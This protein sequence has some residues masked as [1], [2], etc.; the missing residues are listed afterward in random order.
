M[1]RNLAERIRHYGN[2]CNFVLHL[3]L[4]IMKKVFCVAILVLIVVSCGTRSQA[5]EE[6]TLPKDIA[7][8]PERTDDPE[9][10]R[11]AMAELM[12]NIDSLIATESCTDALAWRISAIGAKPCGGPSSFVAYPISREDEI[13]PKIQQLTALQ[14]AFNRKYNMMSDCAVVPA[15]SGVRCENGKAVLVG[16]K[17]TTEEIAE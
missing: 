5:D 11:R 2:I 6:E 14:S 1:D 16:S 15:P 4:K 7:L 17:T 12:R 8:K 3:K 9:P 10:D 13:L